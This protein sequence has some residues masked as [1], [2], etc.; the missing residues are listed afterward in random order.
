[1]PQDSIRWRIRNNVKKLFS[2]HKPKDEIEEDFQRR[3]RVREHGRIHSYHAG[4]CRRGQSHVDPKPTPTPFDDRSTISHEA[5]TMTMESDFRTAALQP[6]LSMMPNLQQAP[7]ARSTHLDFENFDRSTV[8]PSQSAVTH[9]NHGQTKHIDCYDSGHSASCCSSQQSKE[10]AKE[11][12]DVSSGTTFAEELADPEPD[13]LGIQVPENEAEVSVEVSRSSS[14]KRLSSNGSCAGF[15]G[16]EKTT[17]IHTLRS[18]GPSS[19]LT[20]RN[21]IDLD[22]AEEAHRTKPSIPADERSVLSRNPSQI[23]NVSRT[24]SRRSGTAVKSPSQSHRRYRGQNS[25]SDQM[26]AREAQIFEE[27]RKEVRKFMRE[28]E[29]RASLD[30]NL[31]A[32]FYQQPSESIRSLRSPNVQPHTHHR[33]STLSL[34]VF[35]DSRSFATLPIMGVESGRDERAGVH[36]AQS[37]Q[38]LG[39]MRMSPTHYDSRS[40]QPS[41]DQQHYQFPVR[42]T[43]R[44]HVDTRSINSTTRFDAGDQT[45]IRSH[46][47]RPPSI[48]SSVHSMQQRTSPDPSPR[49]LRYPGGPTPVDFR[50][51]TAMDSYSSGS[52]SYSRPFSGF[53]GVYAHSQRPHSVMYPASGYQSE[54]ESHSHDAYARFAGGYPY[55][56]GHPQYS[57]S[58]PNFS[59]PASLV[60]TSSYTHGPNPTPYIPPGGPLVTDVMTPSA[61]PRGQ[62]RD[63]KAIPRL[64]CAAN[65]NMAVSWDANG[66]PIGYHYE[67]PE[68]SVIQRWQGGVHAVEQLKKQKSRGV[69]RRGGDMGGRP[70][71][72]RS[73]GRLHGTIFEE[74]TTYFPDGRGLYGY[75]AGRQRGHGRN[76]SVSL[77]FQFSLTLC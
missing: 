31:S 23:T 34:P 57:Q 67:N 61:P 60:S 10:R 49:H 1:M 19:P 43:S 20:S 73:P 11:Q 24:S 48:A 74:E 59:R 41:V 63:P 25:R 29:R 18:L 56:L 4:M 26:S 22:N 17:R 55:Q 3:E 39:N 30:T 32:G 62:R 54:A 40:N 15:D 75:V 70:P 28:E 33:H 50:N 69:G 42:S 35:Q 65:V 68:D 76:A 16:P 37:M 47:S 44:S 7:Y 36:Y 27:R 64:Q 5:S 8:S 53:S 14:G 13:K 71:N 77:W 6:S 46:H 52:E 58:I 45:S 72:W 12:V 2:S 21:L 9:H 66:E 38:N 51:N